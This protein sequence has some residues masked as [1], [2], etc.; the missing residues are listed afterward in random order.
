MSIILINY[1]GINWNGLGIFHFC[2]FIYLS[3]SG[4]INLSF[5]D[6]ILKVSLQRS[7][8]SIEEPSISIWLI[9]PAKF[10]FIELAAVINNP[11]QPSRIFPIN[12][13]DKNRFA[14]STP[15]K[16]RIFSRNR[17]LRWSQMPI[18]HQ[19]QHW[20][21]S[22]QIELFLCVLAHLKLHSLFT[23]DLNKIMPK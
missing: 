19:L 23:G 13:P 6:T 21:L 16:L 15:I 11:N 9:H 4:F 17:M 8:A 12:L 14:D 20:K 3:I 2:I 1:S 10:S 18:K 22:C 5:K 7:A